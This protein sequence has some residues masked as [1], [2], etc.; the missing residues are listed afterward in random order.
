[1]VILN[2]YNIYISDP[3]MTA[4]ATIE[5]IC[6]CTYKQQCLGPP[7][8]HMGKPVIDRNTFYLPKTLKE[9]E[10]AIQKN[11]QIH[12]DSPENGCSANKAIK[13][14]AKITHLLFRASWITVILFCTILCIVI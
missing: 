1:L 7:L 2:G 11:K 10:S 4:I 9:A 14:W 6:V 8:F 13:K 5:L 12:F 3:G